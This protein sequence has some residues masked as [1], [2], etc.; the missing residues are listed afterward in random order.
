[1]A[2]HVTDFSQ[3]S[4]TIAFSPPSTAQLRRKSGLVEFS[5]S[6]RRCFSAT[7]RL[8]PTIPHPGEANNFPR[9]G[10][11]LVAA[12][13]QVRRRPTREVPMIVAFRSAKESFFPRSERQKSETPFLTPPDALHPFNAYNELEQAKLTGH[14][15]LGS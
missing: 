7:K 15:Y 6:Y 9:I 10:V 14:E 5:R 13:Q 12:T 1:M 11:G 8:L 3:I 2:I 4:A